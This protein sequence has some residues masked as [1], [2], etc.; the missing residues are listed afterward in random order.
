MCLY[1]MVTPDVQ[2]ASLVHVQ[3]DVPPELYS[4]AGNFNPAPPQPIKALKAKNLLE[5]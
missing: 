4:V 2:S 3:P 1:P 5:R